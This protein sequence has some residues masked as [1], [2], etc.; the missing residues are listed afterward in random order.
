MKK[1]LEKNG[2]DVFLIV[3]GS[4]LLAFAS[5]CIFDPL[6]MVTGGVTGLA[7]LVKQVS[8]RMF[9]VPVPLWVTTLACNVPLLT[10]VW[11]RKGLAQ[12]SRILFATLLYSVWLALL[13][14][15]SVVGNDM[16]LGTLFGSLASGFGVGLV[17]CARATTGGTETLAM[18]L[19]DRF[20][21]MPVMRI[22]LFLDGA[23]VCLGVIVFGVRRTLYAIVAVFAIT[24]VSHRL[25]ESRHAPDF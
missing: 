20:T 2:K 10:A 19:K 13:P 12:I 24:Q 22:L 7:I 11:R 18:L 14:K 21:G 16:A 9:G 6:G 1:R 8:A 3:L 17:F 23:I 25:I 4:L 5:K 15:V